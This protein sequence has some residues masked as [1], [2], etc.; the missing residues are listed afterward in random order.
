M[1]IVLGDRFK[2]IEFDARGA[3]LEWSPL[4]VRVGGVVREAIQV[5]CP[6]WIRSQVLAQLGR[7]GYS[8]VRLTA[9]PDAEAYL[10][11]RG[12][13]EDLSH[14]LSSVPPSGVRHSI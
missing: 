8:R 10:P 12:I 1:P 5:R 14:L 3:N 4:K 11:A 2:D 9:N 13:D 6:S 7:D